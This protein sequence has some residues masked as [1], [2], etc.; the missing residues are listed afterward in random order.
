[1][2]AKLFIDILMPQCFELTSRIISP[3]VM[4][5]L[6]NWSDCFTSHQYMSVYWVQLGC[7]LR[8]VY[9]SLKLTKESWA[10]EV[11]SNDIET[12]DGVEVNF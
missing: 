10:M 4:C 3:Q 5:Y 2:G 9:P 7:A 6:M 1:M 11:T 8:Q 12:V